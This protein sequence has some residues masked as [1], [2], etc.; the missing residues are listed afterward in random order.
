MTIEFE[1][2]E[3]EIQNLSLK[4]TVNDVICAMLRNGK[5]DSLRNASSQ[6]VIVESWRKIERPL[7]PRTRIL[8]VWKSWRNEQA[9]VK[10][11]LKTAQRF[12][13]SIMTHMI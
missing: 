6:F 13:W 5:N 4:T 10:Y 2:G 3:H 11:F 8:K 12:D 9:N 1:G 7:P